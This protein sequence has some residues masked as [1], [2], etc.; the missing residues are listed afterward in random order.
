MMLQ[1]SE[2][3]CATS[4]LQ[5]IQ[6]VESHPGFEAPATAAKADSAEYGDNSKTVTD[7]HP[8]GHGEKQASQGAIKN[9]NR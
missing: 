8:Q 4:V 3:M 7:V 5:G 9:T 6:S 1:Q 2:T